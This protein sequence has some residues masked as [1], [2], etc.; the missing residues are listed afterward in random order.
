VS[1][2]AQPPTTAFL[3]RGGDGAGWEGGTWPRTT[4]SRKPF[5]G[6]GGWR[7]RRPEAARVEI[8]SGGFWWPWTR[9]RH[10]NEEES[11]RI[12]PR[13]WGALPLTAGLVS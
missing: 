12:G 11:D 2:M 9:M 13:L 8:R 4:S 10:E 6:V 1:Y 5:Q 7:F 3:Y